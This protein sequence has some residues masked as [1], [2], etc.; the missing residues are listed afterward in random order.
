MSEPDSV[1]RSPNVEGLDVTPIVVTPIV[2]FSW[3][4]F[5]RPSTR[6]T[7]FFIV[8]YFPFRVVS[9]TGYMQNRICVF[10]VCL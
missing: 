8:L 5:V 4:A 2:T 7:E 3:Q 9:L 1:Q 10:R 6:R